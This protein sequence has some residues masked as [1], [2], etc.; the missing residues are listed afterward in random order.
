MVGL[1]DFFFSKK[2]EPKQGEKSGDQIKEDLNRKLKE[3]KKITGQLED[4]KNR[5]LS[6]S[7]LITD[8]IG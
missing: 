2:D 5:L 4:S 3:N 1:T 7:S 6:L 8:F